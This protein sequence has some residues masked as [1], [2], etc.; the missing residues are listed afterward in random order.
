MPFSVLL[1]IAL[2][3]CGWLAA[4]VGSALSCDQDVRFRNLG[5]EATL[6]APVTGDDLL[7]TDVVL[8]AVSH[9]GGM[10]IEHFEFAVTS[11]RRGPVYRGNTYFGFFSPAAL[12]DQV[13]IREAA[14]HR[15]TPDELARG[16]SGSLPAAPPFP[17]PTMRMI[18]RLETVVA[19]GGRHGA[20]FVAGTTPVDPGAW[21]FEAHFKDDPVWPGSLGLEAFLQVIA[22]WADDRWSLPAGTRLRPAVGAPHR[23]T[24][25]GQVTPDRGQVAVQASIAQVQ[26]DPH[27]GGATVLADGFLGVDGRTIYAI[28]GL[29]ID[30]DT[31]G[32]R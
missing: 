6:L 25:R 10:V 31:G 32:S 7:T 24:Y 20:G 28:D 19:D 30:I 5:G 22:G 12:G 26:G 2:Q 21:F 13:G 16:R 8:S 29:G 3:P 14:L 27:R 17:T 4:Y 15:P 11:Q 9:S 23:W 18:D 1:E